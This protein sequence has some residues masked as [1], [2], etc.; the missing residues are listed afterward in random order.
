MSQ[1][2][3]SLICNSNLL[4]KFGKTNKYIKEKIGCTDELIENVRY[5][6]N[7]SMV[8]IDKSDSEISD[9]ISTNTQN[10]EK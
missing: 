8:K 9:V 7:L 4:I 6:H 3:V 10:E 5:L 1:C 2:Q